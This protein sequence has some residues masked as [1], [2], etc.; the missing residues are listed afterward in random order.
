MTRPRAIL[1]DCFGVLYANALN[2]FYERHREFTTNNRAQLDELTH[3]V[4]LGEIT[5]ENAYVEIENLSND[6]ITSADMSD[7]IKRKLVLDEKLVDFIKRLKKHY[8]IGL[9]SNAGQEE[10]TIIYRDNIDS[11]FDAMAISYEVGKE[12]PDQAVY[13]A[14]AERIGVDARDC[15]VVDDST[16]NLEGARNVGM[17]CIYYPEFGVMP[18]ELLALE[19]DVDL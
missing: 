1:F 11:L 2:S 14:C 13:M 10:M 19:I 3:K 12:K 9:L 6:G 17:Q 16:V 5:R 7:E 8:L 15:L 4:N 18:Q